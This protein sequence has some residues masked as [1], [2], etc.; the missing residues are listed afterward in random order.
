MLDIQI[1]D[2]SGSVLTGQPSGIQLGLVELI[3][4]PLEFRT[5]AT[6]T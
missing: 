2:F 5:Q 4:E 1:R 3:G 6:E